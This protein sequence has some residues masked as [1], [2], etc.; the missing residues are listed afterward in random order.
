MTMDHGEA[1]EL[2]EI[3]AAEPE[4][5]ERLMAGDTPEAMAV[6]GH[7]AGC[8]TCVAE[9][10]RMRRVATVVREVVADE[11][12]PA[13]KER[14]LAFIRATGVPRGA[15]ARSTSEPA[16]TAAPVAVAGAPASPVATD[17]P[18]PIRRRRPSLAALAGIAAALLLVGVVGFGAGG[19]FTPAE[20]YDSELAVL[21]DATTT[22]LSLAG[23]GDAHVVPLTPTAA[24]GGA[25]GTLAF[26]PSTGELVVLARGL[27]GPKPGGEY[28]CWV[29][30]AGKKQ[31]IGTMYAAGPGWAW[32]GTSA[33]LAGL[34]A[35]ATFGVS[36][37]PASAKAGEAV[38]VGS[39]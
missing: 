9:L 33:A 13:L 11:P 20:D 1:L 19:G 39:L 3:A 2:I 10:A 34:P 12:D 5:L 17:A 25:Q 24:G 16:A 18:V 23:V 28:G 15:A 7:L 38:L 37:V 4:G 6:A 36:L 32:S 35:G 27:P 21:N 8:P 31:R 29:E 22:A 26:S 30:V 14:T